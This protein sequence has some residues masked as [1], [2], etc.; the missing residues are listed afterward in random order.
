MKY[1]FL[2][3]QIMSHSHAMDKTIYA[4]LDLPFS[5][6]SNI[7]RKIYIAGADTI[8]TVASFS[9]EKRAM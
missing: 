3:M 6:S 9:V 8:R 7:R 2:Y 1:V 4:K 5:K